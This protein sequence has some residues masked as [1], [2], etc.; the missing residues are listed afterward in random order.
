MKTIVVLIINVA[1][2]CF[3]THAQPKT[4]K[5]TSI[6]NYYTIAEQSPAWI[7]A[8]NASVQSQYPN[9]TLIGNSSTT[10]NC[11]AY[12]WHMSNGGSTYWI[13]TPSDNTYWD[14]G[15]YVEVSAAAAPIATKVSYASDDHSAITTT[16]P[17]V[18][19][20]KW[21]SGPVMQHAST[22]TP[23]NESTIKYYA[24]PI[25]TGTN[26]ICTSS[27]YQ[28]IIPSTGTVTYSWSA[29][30]YLT[31]SS[32]VGSSNYYSVSKTSNG[33]TYVAVNVNSSCSG[34]TVSANKPVY[35]G[36]PTIT[37]IQVNTSMCPG[38]S[39][40][41]V[42]TVQGNPT[43]LSWYLSSG[44]SAYVTDYG[45]GSAYFNSYV[46]D[47]YGLTLDMTN[48][49]GTSQAGTSICVD[50]CFSGYS[51]YPNPSKEYL[52]ID[53]V[54][55][56]QINAMPSEVILYSD[57]TQKP[58]YT[59]DHSQI[60]SKV[61]ED[62]IFRIPMTDLPKGIYYLHI[63]PGGNSKQTVDRLRILHE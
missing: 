43:S 38:Y 59:F 9:A 52:A 37:N 11:H 19:I 32:Q 61:G 2:I 40:I 17:G 27:A 7:A 21:G 56:K 5:C 55:A 24:V 10:Y 33:P 25:T 41:V 28:T 23:Y 35:A 4:P 42:A 54:N 14:D 46:V 36:T 60:V 26:T 1:I 12:A 53:L 45:N 47:C 22:Y 51:V 30:P 44:G 15:S 16:S 29:G 48:S 18:F 57:K 50:N 49:C 3:H 62:G 20:S 13:D 31:P 34:T 39:Q 8:T 58:V 6:L 63:T